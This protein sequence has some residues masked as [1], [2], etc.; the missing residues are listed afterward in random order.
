M[1]TKSAGG[2][3]YWALQAVRVTERAT[4]AS[5]EILLNILYLLRFSVL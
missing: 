1:T 5:A 2:P 3:E 4:N